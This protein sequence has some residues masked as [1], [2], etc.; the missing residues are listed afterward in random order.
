MSGMT[1]FQAQQL[2][3]LVDHATAADLA[4]FPPSVRGWVWS[5]RAQGDGC[6]LAFPARIHAVRMPPH[7]C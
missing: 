2:M 7:V 6:P 3:W 5:L 4:C 1:R